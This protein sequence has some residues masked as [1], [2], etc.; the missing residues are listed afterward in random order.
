ML[1]YWTILAFVPIAGLLCFRRECGVKSRKRFLLICFGV[2]FLVM[3]IRAPS[4][5]Q[6]TQS[7]CSIFM[8]IGNATDIFAVLPSAPVYVVYNKLL[9]SLWPNPQAIIV[10]N[11]ALINIGMAVFIYKF[12]DEPAFA[13]LL[14]MLLYMF[15]TSMNASRQYCALSL[16]LLA[17]CQS[18][19]RRWLPCLL[20]AAMAIGTHNTA[21]VFLPCLIFG[22]Y[23]MGLKAFQILIL[24]VGLGVVFYG[25]LFTSFLQWFTR[26]FPRYS[27]YLESGGSPY[28]VYDEGQGRGIFLTIFLSF[29]ILLCLYALWQQKRLTRLQSEVDPQRLQALLGYTAISVILGFLSANNL[30]INR[31]R[32]YFTIYFILLIPYVISFFKRGKAFFQWST[33]TILLI[34]FT[35]QLS[36]NISSVVPYRFFWQ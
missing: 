29:F 28:S 32:F 35:I 20:F 26:L 19:E 17:A 31:I 4:V 33:V 15:L 14:Y 21:V 9:Y 16:M 1:I 2:L 5:G 24:T 8:Q 23:R 18:K 30:M 13:V 11:A 22:P 6:D 10:F 7:Y 27:R 36:D 25:T 3:A 12:S 34:P